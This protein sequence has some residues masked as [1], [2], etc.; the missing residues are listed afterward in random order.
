MLAVST[1]RT[2]NSFNCTTTS[3]HG[4]E[5]FIWGKGFFSVFQLGYISVPTFINS[6]SEL[7]LGF[8][9]PVKHN[10]SPQ[11]DNT[12]EEDNRLHQGKSIN[13]GLNKH[14]FIHHTCVTVQ[15][16][17]PFPTQQKQC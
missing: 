3:E 16:I 10:G 17:T 7:V 8:Q 15:V 14:I 9:H 13:K 12:E 11:E 5:H 4:Q 2:R 1:L 6:V